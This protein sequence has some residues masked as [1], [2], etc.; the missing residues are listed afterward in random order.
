MTRFLLDTNAMGDL[1]NHR[2]GVDL[3]AKKASQDGGVLGTCEV[4]AAELFFGVENSSDREA[5]MNVLNR[6]LA[7]MRT[8]PLTRSASREFGKISAFLKKNGRPIGALDVMIAAIA[9]TTDCIVVT[10]D[11]DMLAVPGLAVENW[12]TSS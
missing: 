1:M 11:S 5:N 3:R 2:Y 7:G 4:V 12:A 6:T 10:R 8:W 9:L